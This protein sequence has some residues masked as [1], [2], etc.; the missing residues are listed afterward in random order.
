MKTQT[1]KEFIKD[2]GILGVVAFFFTAFYYDTKGYGEEL[3]QISQNTAVMASQLI[4]FGE[5][6]SENKQ[7][8][9]KQDEEIKKL[10]KGIAVLET[11]VDILGRR[12]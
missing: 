3:K 7:H 12:K 2:Y 9:E 1:A 6:L 11:R 8:D 5:D 10:G 4:T